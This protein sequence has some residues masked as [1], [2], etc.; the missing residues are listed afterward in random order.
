MKTNTQNQPIELGLVNWTRNYEAALELSKKENKPIFLLFQEVPG[1][2][3]CVNFGN[4]LLS[5]PLLVDVIENEFIPLAIFNNVEG[6]DKT[7][8]NK[9]GEQAW[10]N[11][12]T[13]FL[14]HLGEKVV[15]EIRNPWNPITLLDKICEVL[16]LSKKGVPEYVSLLKK[17]FKIRYGLSRTAY[18]ET[19]C[20]WSGETSLIQHNAVLATEAGWIDGKE[21]VKITYDPNISPITEIDDFAINEGFFL[22]GNHQV[23]KKD[24][25]PQY[26]LKK[27][28]YKYLPLS[29]SQ[30]SLINYMLPYGKNP[31]S[32]LSPTQKELLKQ[33]KKNEGLYPERYDSNIENSWTT[34]VIPY[35]FTA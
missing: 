18:Y 30:R 33:I 23:Y 31:T 35:R 26:Y 24:K 7:I 29:F 3:T 22:T 16:S 15:P 28:L 4:G 8:L 19:P 32:V 17:E 25:A 10:N 27:S 21:V 6:Y 11:P 1:C 20:F 12:V 5:Y 13:Y 9:F 34:D 2:L 14:N